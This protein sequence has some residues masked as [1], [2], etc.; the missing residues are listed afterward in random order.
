MFP[1]ATLKSEL[2]AL[3]KTQVRSSDFKRKV[4]APLDGVSTSYAYCCEFVRRFLRLQPGD[5]CSWTAM[6]YVG[7]SYL[8][9]FLLRPGS[10]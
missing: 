1:D 9:Q 3:V 10:A 7:Q 4:I 8:G 6:F 5:P 2:M